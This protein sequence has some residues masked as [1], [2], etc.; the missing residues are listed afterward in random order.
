MPFS[1]YRRWRERITRVTDWIGA[2][3]GAVIG[4]GAVI[5]L[6]DPLRGL[7]ALGHVWWPRPVFS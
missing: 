7:L 5:W 3:V 4:G 1:R 6:A 2:G